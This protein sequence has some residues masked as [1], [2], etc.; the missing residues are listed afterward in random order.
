[1]TKRM[2]PLLKESVDAAI[3]SKRLAKAA[4]KGRRS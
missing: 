1:M 3:G 2:I 4:V